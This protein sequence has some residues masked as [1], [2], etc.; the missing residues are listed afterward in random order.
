MHREGIVLKVVDLRNVFTDCNDV[1][2]EISDA[3]IYY[4]EE[5]T[6]EGHRSLFLLAYDRVTRRERIIANYFLTDPGFVQ[7]YFSF[8]DDI[9]VVMESGG[10]E[11]WVLRVDKRTGEE[12]NFAKLSFIG[13]FQDCRALDELHVLFYTGPND[14]H[15]ALFGEYKKLTGFSRAAYLYDLEE[16]RYYYAR[17]PRVCRADSS[18]FIPYRQEGEPRFL[19]LDPHGSEEDKMKCFRNMRWLGDGISDNVWECPLFD[20]IVSVKSGEPNIPLELILSAGTSGLVRYAGMD[21]RSLYFRAKYFPTG[22]QRLCAVDR[23]TGRKSVAARLTLSGEERPA[24][25][26]IDAEGG[27]AYR[28]CEEDD[29]GFRVTGVLNSSVDAVYPKELGRFVTCV[30]DRFI[31]ARYVLSDETDSFEFNSIYDVRTGSQKNYEGRCAVKGENVVL[32]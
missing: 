22:D 29:D 30:D 3:V 25:F 14:R 9:V 18:R 16:G 6:E 32:Y 23:G 28:V 20:F 1:L 15:R 12:K 8:P 21:D 7:H 17:D 4:A 11:A 27:R 10:S 2:I 31:L 19:L 13:G 26:S 5:K 24:W